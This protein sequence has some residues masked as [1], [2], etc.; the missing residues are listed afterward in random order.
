MLQIEPEDSCKFLQIIHFTAAPLY[1]QE[2]RIYSGK[3]EKYH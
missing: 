3:A 2:V 1:E